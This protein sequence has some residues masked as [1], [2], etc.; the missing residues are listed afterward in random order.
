MLGVKT[1]MVHIC[2]DITTGDLKIKRCL[3]G[4]FGMF[5]CSARKKNSIRLRVECWA[6]VS[7]DLSLMSGY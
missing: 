1:Y 4:L 7:L 2:K 3:M 5:M 6:I